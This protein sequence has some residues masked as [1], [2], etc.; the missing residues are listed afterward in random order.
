MT[1]QFSL[2]AG[3][4]LALSVL[5]GLPLGTSTASATAATIDLCATAGTMT[6]PPG[7]AGTVPVWGYTEG[8]C[9]G[10][11]AT[12]TKPG[13]PTLE[14]PVGTNVS[15]TLHNNLSVQTGLLFPGVPQP[16]DM[17]GVAPGGT[18]TYTFLAVKPGTFLYEAA[19]LKNAQY[20]VAMGLYGAMNVLPAS[21]KAYGDAQPTQDSSFDALPATLVLSEID[22]ALNK[23]ANPAT[24]NM[25]NF[26]P[27]YGLI[28]GAVHPNTASIP[29]VAGNKVLLRYVNAGVK[30]HSMAALGVHQQVIAYDGNELKYPHTVVAETF[31]PGQTADVIATVPVSAPAGSKYAIYDGSLSLHNS[32]SGTGGMLTFIT[33]GGSTTAS[34]TPKASAVTL[35]PNTTNGAADEGV[36]ATITSTTPITSAELFIDT[37]GV[38]GSGTPMSAT[39]AS[40]GTI[41][42]ATLGGLSAGTH[43]VYVHAQNASGWGP[44]SS[45]PLNL[46]TVGPSTTSLVLTPAVT[47]GSVDVA[48]S[49]SGDDRTSGSSNVTAAEYFVG[50]TGA[51]GMGHPMTVGPLPTIPPSSPAPLDPV[52]ALST[53]MSHVPAANFQGIPA[54]TVATLAE[55]SNVISVHSKDALGNWGAFTTI[56]LIVDKSGP[57]GAAASTTVTPSPN[58]GTTG[59]SVG[60]P[61]VRVRSSFTDAW[62]TV[63]G[64]EGFIDVVGANG[65]G[66]VFTPTDGVWGG[67]SG[68]TD[69]VFAD[70]PLATVAALSNGTHTIY[71]HAKDSAGNW[72]AAVSADLV[73]DKNLP[74]LTSIAVSP[75]PVGGTTGSVTLTANGSDGALGSGLAGGEYWFGTTNPVPGAGIAFTG[76]TTS[77]PV[78]SL[79]GTYIVRARIRDNAGNWSAVVG[80]NLVVD[81]TAPTFTGVTL[82]PP[83]VAAGTASVS[84]TVNGA[85]D[86]V[87]GSGVAGGEFWFGTT[88][89]PAGSGT[90]FNG[91][92]TTVPVATLLAGTYTVGVRIRDGVGNWSTDGSATVTVTGDAT[93]PTFTSIT[94]TPNTVVAGTSTISLAVNGAND[95]GGSGL[96][97]GEYWFGTVNPAPGSGIAFTGMTAPTVSVSALAPGTYTVRARIR[98]G[99]GNWSTGANGI[100]STTLTV[101]FADAIF[102]NDFEAPAAAPWGWTSR[103]TN[104]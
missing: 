18:K 65:S 99:A 1:S 89:P 52:G 103:S 48:V 46:D 35:T 76:L 11:S 47:N 104:T 42:A 41:L 15:I 88:A 37:V 25:R 32:A 58:N 6:L 96:F 53:N 24:F 87:T 2:R 29:A 59:I 9:S 81:K 49:G 92:A 38:N 82:N 20:Q 79:G 71:V 73:I 101:T 74:T 33:V 83:T 64:A 7:T 45:A 69:A 98:D 67:V 44:F 3:L 26:A 13:G 19:L 55:G 61:A 56:S 60:V 77:V 5:V 91:T 28:N 97:G 31:G 40:S 70:I 10:L 39:A 50:V 27:Q 95:I 90:A 34:T 86:G 78:P 68:K 30:L 94:L 72:G 102:A 54:A 66:F 36:T 4:A 51:D 17:T 16:P 75:N 23:L 57:D 85:T 14:Y 84:L 80:T 8:D 12:V 22:P 63:A 21:G 62:S 93:P 43:V 100:R